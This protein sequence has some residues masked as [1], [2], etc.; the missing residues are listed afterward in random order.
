MRQDSVNGKPRN[1]K[2]RQGDQ[3]GLVLHPSWRWGKTVLAKVRNQNITIPSDFKLSL[4]E[5]ATAGDSVVS[6]TAA[7]AWDHPYGV[8]PERTGTA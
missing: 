5:L 1:K 8:W 6:P 4:S 7:E 3:R 2:P